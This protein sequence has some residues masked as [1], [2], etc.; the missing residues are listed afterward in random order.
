METSNIYVIRKGYPGNPYVARIN[1]PLADEMSYFHEP[2]AYDCMD[3]AFFKNDQW[4]TDLIPELSLWEDSDFGDTEY[5][6]RS[7]RFI[8]KG[9][10]HT[11]LVRFEEKLDYP[12]DIE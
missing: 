1:H 9:V 6:Y 11:F 5:P 3:V 8:P 12:D 7:Y 4:V 10:V 2:S